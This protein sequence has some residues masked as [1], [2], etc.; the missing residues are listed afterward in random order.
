MD[1]YLGDPAVARA[2]AAEPPSAPRTLAREADAL[3]VA[4]TESGPTTRRRTFLAG[5]LRACRTIAGILAGER[6]RFTDEIADCY[7][8]RVAPGDPEH[9]RAVHA[10]L[11]ALLPG[12]G[13]LASRLAAHRDRDRLRA[14]ALEPA[15]HA[16]LA[17]LRE[18]TRA[19]VGLTG[20][21]ASM[22]SEGV[23]V[24]I[25]DDAPW[26]GFSRRLGPGRSSVVLNDGAG[27]RALQLA[28]LVAHEAYPGHHTEHVRREELEQPLEQTLLLA[29]TPQ[30]LVAEGAAELGLDVVV[31]PGWGP[32]CASVLAAAGVAPDGLDEESARVAEAVE[33]A[34]T[35][36]ADVRQDAALMLH[37]RGAPE[38]EVIDHLVRWLLVDRDRARRMLAFLA[39]P[40]WRTHTTTYVEGARL[41]RAWLDARPAGQPVG[42]RFAR[43]LDESWTP[44]L[45]AATSDDQVGEIGT[46]GGGGSDG[47]VVRPTGV[48]GA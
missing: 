8:V 24:E 20:S 5:Q 36:L 22:G 39:H 16:L 44:E 33:T 18:R 45:L 9:Y 35:G 28:V 27:H 7:G 37:E 19:T 21:A 42:A 23:R 12:R 41:V 3:L 13:T 46:D 26:S 40:R 32:W 34:M 15:A 38:T 4:T 29:R 6:R 43:L 47:G 48:A 17:D 30:S 31:G 25:V 2:V 14:G 1:A 11:E 10:D